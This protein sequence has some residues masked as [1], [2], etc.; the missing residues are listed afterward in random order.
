MAS[1]QVSDPSGFHRGRRVLPA[2][3]AGDRHGLA[4]G[5]VAGEL[6]AAFA[7]WSSDDAPRRAGA[8]LALAVSLTWTAMAVQAFSRG[9]VLDNCGCF[10]V[11]LAQPLRWWVLVE[12]AEMLAE[13]LTWSLWVLSTSRAR[14]LPAPAT[15]KLVS[16][17]A[18][19]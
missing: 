5:L 17:T 3:R 7:L 13:M 1:A 15:R 19:R 10:G 18:T 12:D 6:A 16:V 8:W 2:R 4:F 14:K 9:L 11:H